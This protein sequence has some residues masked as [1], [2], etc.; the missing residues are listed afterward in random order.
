MGDRQPDYDFFAPT[1]NNLTSGGNPA[2]APIRPASPTASGWGYP[3]GYRPPS[4]RSLP[5]WVIALIVVGVLLFGLSIMS[6]VAIPVFLNQRAKAQWQA[7]RVT[8]PQTFEGADRNTGAAA[9]QF[10]SDFS[11]ASGIGSDAVGVFG[12]VNTQAVIIMAV[13]SGAPWSDAEQA[14][15]R[16]GFVQ[17]FTSQDQ[18]LTTPVQ[19]DPGRLGGWAGCGL[20]SSGIHICF[21]TDADSIVVIVSGTDAGDPATLLR[22]ARAATV[23]RGGSAKIPVPVTVA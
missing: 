8:I 6:A 23:I 10:A 22:D 4:Q 9:K 15:Q 20:T 7:T 21:A 17:G 12:P 2:S 3:P 16:R 13:K 14:A 1:R 19:V 5:G 18:T 11:T